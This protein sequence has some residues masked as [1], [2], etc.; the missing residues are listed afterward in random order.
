ML[1]WRMPCPHCNGPND[2][3]MEGRC[4]S[5]QYCGAGLWV[6]FPDGVPTVAAPS[7]TGRREAVFAW[8]RF[9]KK[10]KQPLS[11][12]GCDARL[13]YVPFWRISALVAI[14]HESPE[15]WQTEESSRIREGAFFEFLESRPVETVPSDEATSDQWTIKPWDLTVPAFREGQWGLESLGVRTQ[16]VALSGCSTHTMSKPD[17][18]WRISTRTDYALTRLTQA[19]ASV[20]VQGSHP[21][22]TNHHI[23]APQVSLIF[24][25]VWLLSDHGRNVVRS[26]E[27]D[28]V[29]G[30]V[31]RQTGAPPSLET[32]TQEVEGEPPALLPHRCSACGADLPVGENLYVFPCANCLQLTVHANRGERQ[33]IMCEFADTASDAG[34]KWFPFWMFEPGPILVPAFPIRNFL[35]LARFG[36][37]MSGQPRTFSHREIFPGQMAGVSLSVEVAAELAGIIDNQ[38]SVKRLRNGADTIPDLSA[39]SQGWINPRLVFAPLK[40]TG[41]ELVDP[42]TGCCLTTSV[43]SP[44]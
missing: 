6:R 30:D 23:I 27:I 31:I 10:Q 11:E 5:C 15:V 17:C 28:G 24:W 8:D 34:D 13:V 36:V 44:S 14:Y 4:V 43:L 33:T 3:A 35:R 21:K 37:I 32:A 39:E 16:T 9:L 29:S 22:N 41:G 2:V 42:L 26:V 18:W 25:P 7:R 12:P 40:S 1:T 20:L 19:V 38:R